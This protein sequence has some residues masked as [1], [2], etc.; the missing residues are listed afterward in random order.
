MLLILGDE[1]HYTRLRYK[2]HRMAF[3]ILSCLLD[4]SHVAQALEER[5]AH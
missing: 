5:Q 1:G 3:V 2:S 4:P